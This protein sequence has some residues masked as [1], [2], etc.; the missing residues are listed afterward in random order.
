MAYCSLACQPVSGSVA[1]TARLDSRGP[2]EHRPR[3]IRP[4][5]T[6]ARVPKPPPPE[7]VMD[8]VE[9]TVRALLIPEAPVTETRMAPPVP[10][11]AFPDVPLPPVELRTEPSVRSPLFEVI[12]IEPPMP[13]EATPPPVPPTVE[14]VPS[15]TSRLCGAVVP[16][17]FS[18]PPAPPLTEGLAA[19]AAPP[20]AL[21]VP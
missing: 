16:P 1:V 20:A 10:P 6:A 3:S 9:R 8:D 11:E 15:P 21:T 4:T 19:D 13:P 18:V 12:V 7:E 14:R 2:N 17:T 5:A